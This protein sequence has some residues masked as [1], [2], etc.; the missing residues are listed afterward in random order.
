[1]KQ[2]LEDS[3]ANREAQLLY[4]NGESKDIGEVPVMD[5]TAEVPENTVESGIQGEPDS[6]KFTYYVIEDLSARGRQQSG[7]R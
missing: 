7:K 5:N 1:M 3:E 4:G 2:E 6:D